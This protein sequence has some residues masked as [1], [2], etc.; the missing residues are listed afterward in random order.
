V[1]K[2]LILADDN[3]TFLMYVGLL[4]KRFGVEVLPAQNG[5]EALKMI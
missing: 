4:L 1:K 3:K 2:N 5:L